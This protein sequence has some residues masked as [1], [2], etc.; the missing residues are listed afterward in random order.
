MMRFAG[1]F[2][3]ELW[4]VIA[5]GAV[6]N[7]APLPEGKAPTNFKECV[8]ASGQVTKSFPPLCIAADGSRFIQE[9]GTETT[10]RRAC[11]DRCGDGECQEIVCMAVG[12]ACP[13]TQ[14]SCP[15][16]CDTLTSP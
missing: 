6:A 4:A 13:E 8:E 16:D 7:A 1:W 3:L 5:W 11:K 14:D 2:L 10:K 12:C 9:E 15:Q